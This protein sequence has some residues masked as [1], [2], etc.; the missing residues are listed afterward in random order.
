MPYG[1]SDHLVDEQFSAG[2][3]VGFAEAYTQGYDQQFRVDSPYSLEAEV[4]RRWLTSLDNL[5]KTTGER[6]DLQGGLGAYQYYA[7]SILGQDQTFFAKDFTGEVA[8]DVLE[9]IAS[10]KRVNDQIKQLGRPDIQSFE[11][12]LQDAMKMQQR[13]DTKSSEMYERGGVASM[14]G[15][16]I[17]AVGGSFS[18]RDPVLLGTLGLGG[19]GRTAAMRVATEMGVAGGLTAVTEV[20]AVAPNRELAGLPEYSL[21]FQVAA[22]V[23]G[24]GL[25]R[26]GLE[27]LGASLGR[28]AAG[29][30]E[31]PR[32]ALD[33]EDAQ[34]RSM[35]EA[36]QRL[37]EARAGAAILDEV[38]FVERN[39]PLGGGEASEARFLA[40]LQDVQRVMGGEA[41][42][43]IARVLPPLPEE[44]IARAADFQIVREQSPQVWAKFEEAQAAVRAIDE[45]TTAIN[46]RLETTTLADAVR[47][48]DSTV[49]DELD[50]LARVVND[51]N[52]PEPVRAA[53]DI[54]GQALV[55]RVGEEQIAKALN[56]AEIAPRKRVQTLR[57]S[58]KATNKRLREATRTVEAER[59]T[60]LKRQEILR[61]LQQK[62]AIDLLGNSMG[63]RVFMPPELNHNV[64]RTRVAEIARAADEAEPR[65]EAITRAVE[66]ENGMIDIGGPLVAADF[67]VPI[68]QPNGTIRE[69]SIREV[70]KEFADDAALVEAVKVCAI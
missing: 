33:F 61:G 52:L 66:D 4:E 44:Y 42:T 26:G 51:L 40:E 57:A 46:T 25:I 5:E 60:I 45:E 7:R 29:R 8:P 22:S 39:N 3:R 19:V 10:F 32:I 41:S 37:P 65:V 21:P 70:Y 68:E 62:E 67:R 13:I 50:N 49:A 16:F 31:E 36:N 1:S 2:P 17:G 48:V 58:R 34:L 38:Q 11:D 35:F 55:T 18:R 56:D 63:G 47:L 14:I 53:A 20:G 43:A 69:M 30:A 54:R 6:V 64:V 12:V 15:Q 23:L 24:A 59:T 27:G 9:S 28:R